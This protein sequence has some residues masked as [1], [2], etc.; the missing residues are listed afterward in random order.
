MI[1]K[2]RKKLKKYRDQMNDQ[3][4]IINPNE[5]STKAMIVYLFVITIQSIN[6]YQYE[7]SRSISTGININ[8]HLT[9]WWNNKIQLG[10]ISSCQLFWRLSFL[11]QLGLYQQLP[12]TWLS[13][14]LP[15]L[16]S[17]SSWFI[18]SFWWFQRPF[19]W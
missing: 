18:R 17:F 1:F 19:W 16:P 12:F 10:I 3:D 9:I 11:C 4:M 14:Q 6:K 15:M 2:V 13:F 5:Q 8:L 7:Y